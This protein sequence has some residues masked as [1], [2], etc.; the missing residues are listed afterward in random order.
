MDV[1]MEQNDDRPEPVADQPVS[2]GSTA[3]EKESPAESTSCPQAT[4]DTQ[5]RVMVQKLPKYFGFKQLKTWFTKIGLDPIKIKPTQ[6]R[7]RRG[8]ASACFLNFRSEEER[9]AAIRVIATSTFNGTVLSAKVADMAP[10]P[11]AERGD[12]NRNQKRGDRLNNER[13]SNE[14]T[15]DPEA[16]ILDIVTNLH[17]LSYED[18]LVTKQNHARELLRK[19]DKKFQFKS[20]G[21][22]PWLKERKGNFCP[23]DVIRPSPITEKYR[24]KCEFSIGY[25]PSN[26]KTIGF[27]L[28]KYKEGVI[29]VIPPYGCRHINDT[30]KKIVQ[31]FT[32]F[33]NTSAYPPFDERTRTNYWHQLTVRTNSAGLSLVCIHFHPQKLDQESVAAEKDRLSY[34][35]S[36]LD[37]SSA[38]T[39][40]YWVSDDKQGGGQRRAESMNEEL[41]YGDKASEFG[42]T[43]LGCKFKISPDAFFQVN[44]P[45]AEV[46]YSSLIE[47]SSVTPQT[48]VLD[49]CCGTGTIGIVMARHVKR[50]IGVELGEAAVRDAEQ[51]ARVNNV[52]NIEFHCAKV[53][54]V[55]EKI[56]R[57]KI[58]RD[59][60]VVVV[61]DPPRSGVHNSVIESLRKARRIQRVIFVA[62]AADNEYTVGNLYSL[63]RSKARNLE[64][65]EDPFYPVKCLPVDLFPL[66]KNVEM[67]FVLNECPLSRKK[68]VWKPCLH[69][70]CFCVVLF[71]CY[72]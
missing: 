59:D 25:S 5:F 64:D 68:N 46:L 49:L 41:I 53:E 20:Q 28:G 72:P 58:Q 11:Y 24:N 1:G 39:F 2:N 19:V 8:T 43:L 60:Q 62:C 9:D 69:E 63:C 55:L 26:E 40:V 50:V 71:C 37:K 57:E 29:V 42:E 45:A 36:T 7:G 6:G 56:L 66:T 44:T 27:K 21:S 15:R 32:T 13:E 65:G 38:P 34:Y 30:M 70:S 17:K 67:V 14:S 22:I 35:C 47:L 31:S 52:D 23:L 12:R 4:A 54:D 48:V 61:L 51:N 10:D 33:I 16:E 18:Q 3:S